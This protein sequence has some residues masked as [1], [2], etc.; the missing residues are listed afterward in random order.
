M[1]R[2]IDRYVGEVAMLD[3]ADVV[4]VDQAQLET[5]IPSPGGAVL[6]VNGAH[7]G[8][9]WVQGCV[10]AG[11]WVETGGRGVLVVNEAHRGCRWARVGGCGWGCGVAG[12]GRGEGGAGSQR[13][14]HGMQV[15]RRG[16]QVDGGGW[17][18]GEF[19]TGSH[20]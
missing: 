15:G 19:G 9:R 1:E 17:G 14:A 20:L 12:G 5:V 2:V 10:G 4:R 6:V 13:G 11:V 18:N 7:R 3:G 8:C 16:A